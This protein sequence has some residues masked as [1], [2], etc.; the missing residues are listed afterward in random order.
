MTNP[1][2]PTR[3]WQAEAICLVAVALLTT[4]V[5]ASGSLDIAAERLFFRAGAVDHWPIARQ[6][7]WRVLYAASTWITASLITAGLAALA[8]SLA[9][10]R[11]HWRGPAIVSLPR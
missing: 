2:R 1:V 8:R 3:R 11:R 7:P 6:L 4:L 5:F 10:A 9:R